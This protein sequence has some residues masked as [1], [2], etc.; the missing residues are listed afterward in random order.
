[1]K[2]D[3]TFAAFRTVHGGKLTKLIQN[4]AL[5]IMM[6]RNLAAICDTKEK[7]S[8][9]AVAAEMIKIVRQ[10]FVLC[11]HKTFPRGCNELIW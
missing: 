1:M 7:F 9:S 10:Q 4:P 11:V 8:R 6:K 3:S 2:K 5:S